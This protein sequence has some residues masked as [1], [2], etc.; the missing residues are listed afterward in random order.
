[1]QQTGARAS[2]TAP[3]KVDRID[4]AAQDEEQTVTEKVVVQAPNKGSTLQDS[5]GMICIADTNGSVH[6]SLDARCKS[7][8]AAR[9]KKEFRASRRINVSAIPLGDRPRPLHSSKSSSGTSGSFVLVSDDDLS[10]SEGELAA[11]AS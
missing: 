11:F 10:E 2:A 4:I 3:S 7:P 5:S 8:R 9:R 6:L 1:M